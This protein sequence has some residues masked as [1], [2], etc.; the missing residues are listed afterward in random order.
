MGNLRNCNHEQ[1]DN[2]ID[3][4]IRHIR[5]N[6]KPTKLIRQYPYIQHWIN[7]E[8]TEKEGKKTISQLKNNKSHGSDGIPREAYKAPAPWVTRQSTIIM[9]Q[10]NQGAQLPK[11]WVEGAMVHIYKNK[12]KPEDWNSYRPICLAQIIYK[13]WPQLITQRLEKYRTS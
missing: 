7:P 5:G 12:G 11:E 13:I 3:M 4:D 1:Q 6:A 8:Y 9:N 10:I 2:H